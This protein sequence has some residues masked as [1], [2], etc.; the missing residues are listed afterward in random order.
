MELKDY[1]DRLDHIDSQIV[2]LFKARMETV[3]EIGLYKKAHDLPVLASGREQEILQRIAQLCGEE[4][5]PYGQE[6][7]TTL[8]A[9][10]RD[11]QD[12]LLR[13]G[14]VE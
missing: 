9:L 13:E 6:L 2:E 4:L 12:R 14:E 5:A 8:M 7:F 10:S 1:R 3:K 11:Y